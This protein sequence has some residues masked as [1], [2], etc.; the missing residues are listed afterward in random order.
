MSD[1]V[2]EIARA[3]LYEGHMLFPYRPSAL[4]NRQRWTLGGVYPPAYARATAD[5][6]RVSFECLVEGEAPRLDVEVRFL[7]YGEDG[8]AVERAVGVGPIAAQPGRVEA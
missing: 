4:K 1:V 7:E 6:S 8:R 2:R 5:R 3:V